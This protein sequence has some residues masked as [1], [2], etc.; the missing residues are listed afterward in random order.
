MR[1]SLAIAFAT[2]FLYGKTVVDTD[3][4]AKPRSNLPDDDD[5]KL[6]RGPRT[7]VTPSMITGRSAPIVG[8]GNNL[9]LDITEVELPPLIERL[10]AESPT[11]LENEKMDENKRAPFAGL[12]KDM[13][14]AD[15]YLSVVSLSRQ[16]E[17]CSDD[18]DVSKVFEICNCV[19]EIERPIFW[20]NPKTFPQDKHYPNNHNYCKNLTKL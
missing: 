17:V 8:Q 11:V 19:L 7:S 6:I 4:T 15:E 9:N 12:L 5:Q 14:L 18:L 20:N 1:L 13:E 10:E 16:L 2:T 3:L